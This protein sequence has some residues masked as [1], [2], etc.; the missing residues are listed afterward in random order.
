MAKSEAMRYRAAL[1]AAARGLWLGALDYFDFFDQ[2]D[3]VIKF[4]LPMAWQMGAAECGVS[5][6]DY[7]PAEKL[8][9]SRVIADEM[10]YIDGLAQFIVA[11]SKAEGGKLGAVGGTGGIMGRIDIWINRYEQVRQKAMVMACADVK[12]RWVLGDAEHCLSCLKLNG[13]VKRNSY[14]QKTG[15]LPRVPGAD[16]LICQGWLCQCTLELTDEPCSKGPLP[17]LP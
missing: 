16:Y 17:K 2:M 7:S 10:L 11:G 14:W 8:A 13:K 3:R 9:L 5:P 1:R 4:F 12:S 15:I 6:A